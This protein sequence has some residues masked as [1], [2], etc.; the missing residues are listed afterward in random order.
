MTDLFSEPIELSN[1]SQHAFWKDPAVSPH[2]IFVTADF[3]WGPNEAHYSP[4]RYTISAY[5]LQDSDSLDTDEYFL[6]DRYMTVRE[7][8]SIETPDLLVFE[9]QEILGRLRRR[10]AYER[11]QKSG[12]P[13]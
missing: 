6:D 2:P 8:D 11:A 7:Y 4:H 12:H 9:R 3:V 13:K 5:T 10:A 1:Q